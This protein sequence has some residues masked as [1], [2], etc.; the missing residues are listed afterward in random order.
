MGRR[1][2]GRKR[3]LAGRARGRDARPERFVDVRVERS[4]KG[5]RRG[6]AKVTKRSR[7]NGNV[8]EE[9]YEL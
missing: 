2:R 1:R 6:S 8:T 3:R 9:S 4:P 5:R 7:R